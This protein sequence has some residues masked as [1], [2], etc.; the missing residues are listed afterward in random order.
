MLTYD[1]LTPEIMD[2]YKVI[3]NCTPVGMYRRADNIPIFHTNIS[4]PTICFMI[5]YIIRDTTLFMKKGADKGA[6]TKKRFRNALIASLWCMGYMEQ[7]V[8]V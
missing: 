6:I 5:C 8:K 2:E 3:V 7:I 4:H 1:Q